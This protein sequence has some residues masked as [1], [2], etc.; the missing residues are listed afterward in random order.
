MVMMHVVTCTGRTIVVTKLLNFFF[1]LFLREFTV[2]E[3][4]AVVIYLAN[5]CQK[6]V[7]NK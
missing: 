5:K 7:Q 3:A 4:P 6:T 2:G 1:T